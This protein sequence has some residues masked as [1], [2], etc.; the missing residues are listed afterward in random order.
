MPPAQPPAA[1]P[2]AVPEDADA[3]LEEHGL[4]PPESL[5]AG[6]DFARFLRE[7]VPE[8]LRRRALRRLWRVNPVLANVDGLVDYGE[9]FTDASRV[10][11]ALATA[12]RVGRGFLK[13]DKIIADEAQPTPEKESADAPLEP[14]L[15]VDETTPV[16]DV[17]PEL[18]PAAEEDAVAARPRPKRMRF[19]HG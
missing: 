15:F 13:K 7:G 19:E 14:A 18:P 4:A 17:S 6:A 10:P 1:P 11:D 5:D 9:D 3:Y 2:A 12:Y 8:A 16:A